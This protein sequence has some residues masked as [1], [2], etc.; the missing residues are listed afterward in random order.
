MKKTTLAVVAA[1]ASACAFGEMTTKLVETV[2]DRAPSYLP[3]G[4]KLKLIWNDEF[5]GDKLDKSKWGFRLFFW[6]T[7]H[8]AWVGDEGVEVSGGYC[9]LKLVERNGE[10]YSTQ[11]Q[12][13]S[14]L[15][16]QPKGHF[17]GGIWPFAKREKPK[18]QHKYGY[19]ECRARTQTQPGWW[20]A[21][22]LQAPGI[23]ATLDP[24]QSGVECDILESFMPGYVVP[25]CLHYNGYGADYQGFRAHRI[26]APSGLKPEDNIKLDH[27]E[28]FHTY[29]VLW[30][31][32]GYTF[33]IDGKQSG[34]KVGQ[35]EGEA[36]SHTEQFILLS[37][38][39]R[40]YRNSGVASAEIRGAK[41]PDEFTVDYV[42]VYDLA[43]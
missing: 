27:P 29:A 11:L 19:Y 25:H 39:I 15:Y 36:V 10:F 2:K 6:G 21:F 5:D 16:D 3:E 9:H 12:T 33:F 22:W 28:E 35:G 37:T 32:D 18:F 42:R 41:L 8:P 20:S 24:G 43:E 40:D 17:Q 30:E 23:G 31:P 4:K 1:C 38:E 7:R 13:G 14:L 34:F 26:P